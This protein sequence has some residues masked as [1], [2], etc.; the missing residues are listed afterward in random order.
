MFFVLY[1]G[2]ALLA[3]STTTQVSTTTPAA[4]AHENAEFTAWPNPFSTELTVETSNENCSFV[5]LLDG[6]GQPI[7]A[8]DLLR[9]RPMKPGKPM[10]FN[11]NSI[12]GLPNGAYLVVFYSASDVI[13]H[14][15]Q[16][17]KQ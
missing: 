4:S 17:R 9:K 8:D 3:T 1:I 5:S 12:S 11:G 15:E 10:S 13:L 6:N 2:A 16:V 14:T 7:G